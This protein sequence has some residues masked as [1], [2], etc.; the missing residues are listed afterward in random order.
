M[1]MI[2]FTG[3][4]PELKKVSFTSLLHKKGDMGLIEA[5]AIMDKIL[6]DEIV[7]V[8]V[9]NY[10]TACE[11]VDDANQLGFICNLEL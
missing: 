11:I 9:E 10:D 6:D 4:K 5:K 3:C 7:E 8:M 1:P 2:I